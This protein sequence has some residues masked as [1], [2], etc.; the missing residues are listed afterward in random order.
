M[1]GLPNRGP[2][3]VRQLFEVQGLTLDR[4]RAAV[5]GRLDR[6]R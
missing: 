1:L 2:S 6:G 5:V 4:L 3:P